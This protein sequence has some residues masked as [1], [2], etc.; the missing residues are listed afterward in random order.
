MN[1]NSSVKDQGEFLIRLAIILLIIFNLPLLLG[2]T[3]YFVVWHSV[4]SLNNII[5]YLQKNNFNSG[6]AVARQIVFYSLVAIAGI[7]LF[8][9]AGFMFISANAMTGYL[10]LGLAVLTAPH[11]QIMHE[12]YN[13]LRQIHST[14]K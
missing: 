6:K 4:L 14:E 7:F 9:T 11:M 2:F 10:F 12:M 1:R 13:S 5:T 8:G 3:F